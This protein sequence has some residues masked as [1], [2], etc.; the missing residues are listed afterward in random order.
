MRSTPRT[1]PS[2]RRTGS[3]ATCRGGARAAEPASQLSRRAPFPES[4]SQP[5]RDGLVFRPR[6]QGSET[7]SAAGAK[8]LPERLLVLGGDAVGLEIAQAYTRV[9]STVTVVEGEERLIPRRSA[10]ELTARQTEESTTA[11]VRRSG[12]RSVAG[13]EVWGAWRASALRFL[14]CQN[15]SPDATRGN[16]CRSRGLDARRSLAG[17]GPYR[18][19][20]DDRNQ[21]SPLAHAPVSL[22]H[23]R[24]STCAH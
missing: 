8:E 17:V 20:V 2:M 24:L 1:C 18:A 4:V 22:A 11:Q 7:P 3:R 19:R 16:G 15:R 14:S 21:S 10:D 23:D 6:V 12:L 9:S 5:A 13:N